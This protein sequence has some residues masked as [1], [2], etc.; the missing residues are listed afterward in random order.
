MQ[1]LHILVTNDDGIDSAGLLALRR[2]LAP[3]GDVSII[4]PEHNWSVCGH[5]KTMDR[6]LRV[7]EVELADGFPAFTTDGTPSDCVS[8]G[9]LGFLPR[10][11]HLVV[12]GINMGANLGEDI[13]Y[14]GTV[15]AA[16]ESLISGLPAIAVS[17]TRGE[18]WGFGP[19]ANFAAH[20]LRQ[21]EHFGI[22]GDVILNVNVPNVP[23]GQITGVEVTRLGKRLYKDKLIER[24]DPYGRKYYWIGGER[25]GGEAAAGTD[26]AAIDQ[27]RISVTPIHLDLTSHRLISTLKKWGLDGW[28]PRKE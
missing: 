9:V 18:G 19:A 22:G 7:R 11:P 14:S 3:I 23:I 6:P 24:T 17:L 15:A 25:P 2:A 4:A 10:K 13:T 1:R 8:L 26:I 28:N 16:M 5:S 21:V 27:N 12:A 20:L